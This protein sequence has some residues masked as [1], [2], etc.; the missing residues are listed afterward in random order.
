MIAIRNT[1]KTPG[2]DGDSF[3]VEINHESSIINPRSLADSGHPVR[4]ADRL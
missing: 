4:L 1:E 2:G 3:I